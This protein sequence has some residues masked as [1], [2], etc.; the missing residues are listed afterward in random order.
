VR[1]AWGTGSAEA[2]PQLIRSLEDSSARVRM[3]AA[4]RLGRLRT[5]QDPSAVVPALV[6]TLKDPDAGVRR[7]VAEALERLGPQAR[8]AAA[9]LE[10]AARNDTD[11]EV[12]REAKEAFERVSGQEDKD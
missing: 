6:R 5:G 11:P 1:A 9:A 7:E 12:R 2:N 8:E 4:G 3:V 10:E